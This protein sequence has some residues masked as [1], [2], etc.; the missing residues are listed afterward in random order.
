[1]SPLSVPLRVYWLADLTK[2]LDSGLDDTFESLTESFR[3][4]TRKI[5]LTVRFPGA[6]IAPTKRTIAD[7]HTGWLNSDLKASIM[8]IN[9][10][11]S[12]FIRIFQTT[13][14]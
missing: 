3:P 10:S 8:G 13:L 1:M 7:P 12:K 11:G 6:N 5:A 2:P 4:M 14:S 9:S